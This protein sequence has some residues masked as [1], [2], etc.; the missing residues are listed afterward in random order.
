MLTV[1]SPD[2]ESM[3][4]LCSSNHPKPETEQTKAEKEAKWH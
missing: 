1:T 2:T 4:C 3:P